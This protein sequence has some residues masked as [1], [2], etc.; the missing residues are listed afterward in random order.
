[1][2]R[3][4]MKQFCRIVSR[5]MHTLPTEFYPFLQN[6]V[7]DVLD[8]PDDEMLRQSGFTQEEIEAGDTLFGLF[9]PFT[10]AEPPQGAPSE[11]DPDPQLSPDFDTPHRLWIFKRPHEEEFPDPKQLRI[12]VRK[13]VIHELAHHFGFAEK[14][15]EKFDSN[16]DPF[17]DDGDEEQKEE[18]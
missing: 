15:L 6:L 8:E 14:D 11:D 3:M 16:P 10:Y 2:K 18:G 5:V 7:V 4:S 1:M 9:E 13:T 17:G 12:E